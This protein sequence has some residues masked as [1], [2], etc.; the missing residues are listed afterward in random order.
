[1][2]NVH[3]KKPKKATTKKQPHFLENHSGKAIVNYEC[4]LWCRFKHAQVDI[5]GSIVLGIKDK[6]RKFPKIARIIIVIC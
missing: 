5:Q 6:Q 3:T 2:E 1:M 4:T